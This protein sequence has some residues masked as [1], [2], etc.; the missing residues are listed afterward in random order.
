MIIGEF[1][2]WSVDAGFVLALPLHQE[3]LELDSVGVSTK[4]HVAIFVAWP[5]LGGGLFVRY[6]YLDKNFD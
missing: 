2:N 3:D 1:L 5:W 6:K 4:D